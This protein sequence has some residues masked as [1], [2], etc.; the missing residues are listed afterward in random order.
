MFVP[1]IIS[2]QK[3]IAFTEQYQPPANSAVANAAPVAAPA[4]KP[5]VQKASMQKASPKPKKQDKKKA[6]TV[7]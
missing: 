7:Y 3:I 5:G 2:K 6:T 1:G 4:A